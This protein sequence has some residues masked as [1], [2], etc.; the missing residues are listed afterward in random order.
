VGYVSVQ[1]PEEGEFGAAAVP[2]AGSAV[3][4]CEYGA[5]VGVD[6]DAVFDVRLVL[7]GGYFALGLVV[8]LVVKLGVPVGQEQAVQ[9]AQSGCLVCAGG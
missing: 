3:P 5:V 2:W 7:P 1:G 8:C 4:W 9:E 6:A